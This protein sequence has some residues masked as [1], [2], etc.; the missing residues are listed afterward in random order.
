VAAV[1]ANVPVHRR[2]G[3]QD[4]EGSA[5]REERGDA[6]RRPAPCVRSDGRRRPYPRDDARSALGRGIGA[7]ALAALFAL[8]GL[9]QQ[10]AGRPPARPAAA[11][12]ARGAQEAAL[13]N[14][15]PSLRAQA[16]TRAGWVRFR[17]DSVLP[18]LMRKYDVQMWV[19]CGRE[20]NDDPVYAQLVPGLGSTMGRRTILVFY[21]PG[22]GRP[23]ERLALGSG[24][25]GGLYRPV[26]D[27]AL[28]RRMGS[29]GQDR[30]VLL[31]RVVEER[32]PRSIAIDVS[33]GD[34]YADGLS[35]GDLG[36]LEQ[37]LGPTYRPR[38]RYAEGLV[39]D[40]FAVR[41]PGMLET[42]VP[43]QQ[44]AHDLIATAFSREVITPG[45]TRAS[46]VAWWARQ[47]LN[48]LGL[49]A[50]FDPYVTVQ[51]R[52]AD[53][54]T[55]GDPVL[56]PGDV[57]HIDFGITGLGL[58]T[59]TQHMAYILRPG[60][61]APPP[62]LVAALRNTNRLQDI[63]LGEMRAG[64]TGNEVLTASLAAMR[65]AG[66]DG[67]VYGHPV[68]DHGHAAGPYVGLWDR[69]DPIAGRG[70]VRFLPDTWHSVELAAT[71]AVPEWGNQRVTM[72]EEEDALI[73]PDGSARWVLGRQSQLLLVR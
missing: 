14:P 64:R 36:Q 66:I 7:A 27:T 56:L 17:L 6:G 43:L 59:D 33:P 5:G 8:P 52:G 29:F 10:T 68:G 50:W 55:L 42:Y 51:R 37:A 63:V 25:G 23:L 61:T 24:G 67:A 60:E 21:D 47:K 41:A 26:R 16:A 22:D 35:A 44:L 40:Y 38:L 46:D 62:G 71:T 54:D 9:A 31:R 49:G 69:Q 15:L 2:T 4:G 18:A 48:D 73:A 65:S 11:T 70:D 32:D 53:G 34:A 20:N 30:F 39:L 12:R 3:A 13:A 58:N 72:Y 57:L 1:R 19:V 45:T 28:A